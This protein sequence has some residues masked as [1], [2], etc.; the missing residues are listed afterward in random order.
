MRF[1]LPFK[2]FINPSGI[3][4]NV[5]ADQLRGSNSHPTVF[6]WVCSCL[7]TPS[8]SVFTFCHSYEVGSYLDKDGSGILLFSLS[9]ITVGVLSDFIIGGGVVFNFS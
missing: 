8:L 2:K 4:L 6:P 7:S 3:G 1:S 9:F 5:N